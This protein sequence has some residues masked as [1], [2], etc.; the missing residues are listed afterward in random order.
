MKEGGV[1]AVSQLLCVTQEIWDDEEDYSGPER[2]FLARRMES[3]WA[4]GTWH[5]LNLGLVS[6]QLQTELLKAIDYTVES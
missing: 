2:G 5:L 4:A 6:C 1:P 3:G